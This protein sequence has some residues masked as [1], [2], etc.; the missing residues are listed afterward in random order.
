MGIPGSTPARIASTATTRSGS[1]IRRATNAEPDE[2]QI[3][4]GPDR[5]DPADPGHA[6]RRR[7]VND[8]VLAATAAGQLPHPRGGGAGHVIDMFA[9]SG[10]PLRQVPAQAAGVLHCPPPDLE[11]GRPA[12]QLPIPGEG[13]VDLRDT[14]IM[15]DRW[16]MPITA[17]QQHVPRSGTPH[18]R[19]FVLRMRYAIDDGSSSCVS[20][21]RS[22]ASRLARRPSPAW[23]GPSRRCRSAWLCWPGG[24]GL[25]RRSCARW[26]R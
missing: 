22:C 4:L 21:G 6:C 11:P 25:G 5:A 24:A 8:V 9:A 10:Q 14:T 26:W 17:G 19:R 1:R 7:G 13:G 23:R 15:P 2:G 3:K 16:R 12:R 18:G 20:G